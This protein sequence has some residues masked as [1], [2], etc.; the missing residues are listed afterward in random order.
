MI[1][2][3]NT[4][5]GD[6]SPEVIINLGNTNASYNSSMINK[7][8][9]VRNCAHKVRMFELM[10]DNDIPCLTWFDLRVPSQRMTA[11]DW[12]DS[13]NRLIFR[14]LDGDFRYGKESTRIDNG[15]WDYA[16][17]KE[18]R[19]FEFRALC[20]NGDVFKLFI[21]DGDA[22]RLK[23]DTTRFVRIDTV[24]S[25]IKDIAHEVYQALGI[26]L[27]GLDIMLTGDKG[28]LVIEVNSAPGMNDSSIKA[29]FNLIREE[30]GLIALD[31]DTKLDDDVDDLVYGEDGDDYE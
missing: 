8:E 24:P 3:F 18:E 1:A 9:H 14:R 16:T 26:N 19:I 15:H 25:T 31:D 30:H 12:A 13:G 4:Y 17:V 22:L 23:K 11:H 28:F 27:C 29:L 10:R 7:P 20:Y 21:K 6:I 5:L 2:M